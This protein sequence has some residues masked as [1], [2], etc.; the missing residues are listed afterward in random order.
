M[1]QFKEG[2]R[3][4]HLNSNIKGLIIKVLD[5]GFYIVKDIETDMDLDLHGREL[6]LHED[7]KIKSAPIKDLK[8]SSLISQSKVE[9]IIKS[10]DL[11]FNRIPKSFSNKYPNKLEAQLA[12]AKFIIEQNSNNYKKI[13]LIHGKGNGILKQALEKELRKNSK[14]KEFY[15]PEM[16]LALK[17]SKIQIEFK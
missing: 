17:D 2:D 8:K 14:I 16:I 11:H 13:I 1:Y 5:K 15:D 10:F 9:K 4:S 12:Y 6:V 7:I 3:V